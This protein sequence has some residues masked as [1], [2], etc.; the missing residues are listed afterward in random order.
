[1]DDQHDQ[2]SLGKTCKR[3]LDIFYSKT[4]WSIY[5]NYKTAAELVPTIRSVCITLS[6]EP[7]CKDIGFLVSRHPE[8][9]R[10][11]VCPVPNVDDRIF[12]RIQQV[13]LSNR[14]IRSGNPLNILKNNLM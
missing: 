1:M 11:K 14:E 6:W 7:E 2:L 9:E 4:T 8:I 10:F 12:R 3:L 5:C 13:F